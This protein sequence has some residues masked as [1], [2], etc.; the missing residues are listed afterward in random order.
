MKK[1]TDQEIDTAMKMASKIIQD[2]IADPSEFVEI[3]KSFQTTYNLHLDTLGIIAEMTRNMLLGLVNPQEFLQELITAGIPANDAKAI[4]TEINQK[5]FV[6]LR[7]Q[8]RKESV[9]TTPQQPRPIT[10]TAPLPQRPVSQPVARRNVGPS[11]RDVLSAVTNVSKPAVSEKLLEDHEEPH[12]EFRAPAQHFPPPA[13]LPGA[14][15]P[16]PQPYASD[17]YREPLD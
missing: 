11:L 17:P 6:P 10:Q 13:N 14:L 5:I 12:I 2:K 4:M 16:L 9:G 1:F 3:I 8:M 15:H 7:E